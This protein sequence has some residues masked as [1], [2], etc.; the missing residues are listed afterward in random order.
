VNEEALAQ[1]GLSRQKQT[2]KQTLL[3]VTTGRNSAAGS[4]S[5]ASWTSAFA[6]QVSTL[7]LKVN[8]PMQFWQVK[9]E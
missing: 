7:N 1:W 2:N 8:F 9:L 3:L 6:F 5:L 4:S